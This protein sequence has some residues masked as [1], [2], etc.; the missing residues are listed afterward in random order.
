MELLSVPRSSFYYKS[1]RNTREAFRDSVLQ[2]EILLIYEKWPFCGYPRVTQALNKMGYKVNHKRVRRLRSELG[3]KTVYPRP[4]FNTSEANPSHKKYPYLLRNLAI[5]QPNQ[6]WAIDIT[7]TAVNGHRAYII[8][9]IDLFSR[10]VLSYAVVNT[11]D[12][13]HCVEVLERAVR[14]YGR[15]DIFNSDQGSQF[16]SERFTSELIER[17]IK[18]S[19]DGKGRALDNAKMERFW[20]A[21][22]YEDIKIKDYQSLPQLRLGVQSYVNFYNTKR[23]HSA[24]AYQTP[25]EV[26]MQTCKEKNKSYSKSGPST[27]IL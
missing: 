21:L 23:Y 20:W 9:I 3:L 17:K 5:E 16:T 22:K 8:A 26:Y 1:K 24:L 6:V 2:E 4:R 7:Y 14:H 27:L 12:A 19:M 11:M 10:K 15:P 13:E 25:D 18:I